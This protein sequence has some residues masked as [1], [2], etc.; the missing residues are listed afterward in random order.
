MANPYDLLGIKKTATAD[1][2]KKAY[3]KLARTLHPDVNPDKN[4]ADKFKAVT[5]A[6]DLLSDPDKRRRFDAGEIDGEGNPTPFGGGFNGTGGFGGGNNGFQGARYA[7]HQINPEDLAAM[8][9]GGFSSSSG[10][11]GFDFSDLFGM[12]QAG[13]GKRRASAYEEPIDNDITYTLS[14]PFDLSVTGGETTV[15]LDNG[16]RLKVKIPAGVTNESVLRLKGQGKSGFGRTGDALIKII[17]QKSA[18][19][20][21]EGNHILVT[22]PISLKEAILGAKITVPT[23]FGAVRMNIPPYSGSGKVLRL[24]GKGIKDKGDLLVTLTVTLPDKP[25]TALTDFM[26]SWEEPYQNLRQF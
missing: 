20:T 13:A 19:Y 14:I 22:V 9:G 26:K 17:V 24:K 23:P 1:E 25:D 4:A 11:G 16:K 18:L 12:G 21:R 5:A 7:G 8:F 10:F 3:R 6:Y 2:I 15:S